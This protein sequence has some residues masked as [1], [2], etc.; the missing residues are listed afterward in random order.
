LGSITDIAWRAAITMDGGD[1]GR[2]VIDAAEFETNAD[3]Q[4]WV[5]AVLVSR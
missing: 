3:A 4:P 1:D 2:I 5:R